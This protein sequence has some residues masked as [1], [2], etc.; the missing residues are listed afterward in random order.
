MKQKTMRMLALLCLPFASAVIG[1][2]SAQIP[3]AHTPPPGSKGPIKPLGCGYSSVPA[4]IL[5]NCTDPIRPGIPD[6]R[7]YWEGEAMGSAPH[8]ERI[9]QCDDRIVWTS[10]CV[11]HD[12]RHANGN[13]SDG[14]DDFSAI[15][16]VPIKVAGIFNATCSMLKPGGTITA[17]TRCLNRDGSLFIDWGGQTGTLRRTNHT[18][19]PAGFSKPCDRQ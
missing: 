15:A 14:V 5:A 17:V 1:C 19:A 2:P 7:G 4:P 16:C 10:G 18:V 11:V 9:E 13:V 8:W 12:F 6:M 3:T